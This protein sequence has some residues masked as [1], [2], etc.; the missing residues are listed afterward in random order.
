MEIIS[1]YFNHQNIINIVFS[2]D[3]GYIKYFSVALQSLIENS[4]SNYY[5]NIIVFEKDI[6]N[7]NKRIL[8]NML[9]INFNIKFINVNEY[10]KY[11]LPNVNLYSKKYWS[12]SMFYRILI[13][14]ILQNF[15][16]VLYI[17][18]DVC[19][20]SDLVEIF[21]LN[22]DDKSILAVKDSASPILSSNKVRYSHLKEILNLKNPQLYFNSGVLLFNVS[23]IKK[24]LN[25]YLKN[26]TLGLKNRNLLFPDQDLLN[27]VFENDV[28]LI[29]GKWNCMYDTWICNSDKYKKYLSPDDYNTW[30][31]NK[32]K[33][34][35][36]HYT[37]SL[38]PWIYPENDT[39]EIFWK[40]A[41]KS[42]FYEEIIYSNM[43][44]QI[45]SRTTINNAIHR[46]SIYL[47]YLRCKILKIFSFG[48]IR[49]HYEEKCERLKCQVRDY[50]KTIKAK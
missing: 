15:D 14:A 28:Q 32:E 26:L 16:K 5:Y 12:E 23:K 38:K 9:P 18:S 4:N 24:D 46:K 29:S 30:L 48:K 21:N 43:K 44:S 40:Y 33:P 10:I 7:R 19:I 37:S 35:I 36:L 27:I 41:R 11:Y 8:N 31:Q 1:P 47:N 17:D 42:P 45:I 50:R 20:T 49:N 39:A 34:C 13:P 6:S 2:P 22:F 3:N 25:N